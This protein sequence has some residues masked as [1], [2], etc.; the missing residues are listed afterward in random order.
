ML[1]AREFKEVTVSTQDLNIQA[2]E[3]LIKFHPEALW[4]LAIDGEYW[5]K[6]DGPTRIET[7][8]DGY[9]A[10]VLLAL[11]QGVLKLDLEYTFEDILKYHHIALSA[12]KNKKEGLSIGQVRKTNSKI[13]ISPGC[14]SEAGVEMI[15]ADDNPINGVLAEDSVDATAIVAFNKKF[16]PKVNAMLDR[17]KTFTE[18]ELIEL[19]RIEYEKHIKERMITNCALAPPNGWGP[20]TAR[21]E[22]TGDWLALQMEK[23]SSISKSSQKEKKEDVLVRAKLAI[24]QGL[25]LMFYSPNKFTTT[26]PILFSEH[27]QWLISEALKRYYQAILKAKNL[28]E[29]LIAMSYLIKHC[30]WTHPFIDGNNRVFVNVLLSLLCLQQGIL[31]GIFYRPNIFEGMSIKELCGYLREAFAVS[32]TL[33]RDP[34]ATVFDYSNSKLHPEMKEKFQ[35]AAQKL[36][37]NANLMLEH[38][39]RQ[40]KDDFPSIL[41]LV[42]LSKLYKMPDLLKGFVPK[43]IAIQAT[44]LK[45]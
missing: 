20:M 23:D 9:V 40:K 11:A 30:A 7:E 16:H 15:Y 4:M 38:L 6:D 19:T 2:L 1:H 3:K 10:G 31:P 27:L 45:R 18:T 43:D 26:N 22:R 12:L 13:I 14:A 39:K 29:K 41:T 28:D 35:E 5:K 44:Q 33:L 21:G 17:G 25:G 24:K 34:N 8:D 36:L 42:T 37:N 32:E